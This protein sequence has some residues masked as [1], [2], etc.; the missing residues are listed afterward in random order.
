MA[1][2]SLMRDGREYLHF[3]EAAERIGVHPF[4][5]YDCIVYDRLPFIWVGTERYIAVDCLHKIKK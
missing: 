3:A 4:M 1:E 2:K 5:V